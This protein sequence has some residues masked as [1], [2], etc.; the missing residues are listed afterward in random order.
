MQVGLM[1]SG[2]M[3]AEDEPSRLLT[4]YN[5]TVCFFLNLFKIINSIENL[6]QSLE[7]VFLHLCVNDQNRI[8]QNPINSIVEDGQN[9]ISH[10]VDNQNIALS[11]VTNGETPH[12]E[13]RKKEL[14]KN[15]KLK[16]RK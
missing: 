11:D 9:D 4:K 12:S 14:V 16:T 2:R 13:I 10:D 1:R 8:Q 3:L 15:R 6:F 7:N 5:Q